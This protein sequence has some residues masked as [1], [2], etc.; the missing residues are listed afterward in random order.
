MLSGYQVSKQ[1]VL[2]M[3]L[4]L[5]L[6]SLA[7]HMF[8]EGDCKFLAKNLLQLLNSSQIILW[9]VVCHYISEI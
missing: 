7:V 5:A 9:T 6:F 1:K 3:S 8:Q 4:E 2:G